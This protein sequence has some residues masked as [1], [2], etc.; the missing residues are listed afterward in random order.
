M[1]PPPPTA[2]TFLETKWSFFVAGL[3]RLAEGRGTR[4]RLSVSQQENN[5]KFSSRHL[6]P[7]KYN[8]LTTAKITKN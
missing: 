3:L 7:S 4:H 5:G 8:E 1:T 6:S 2:H